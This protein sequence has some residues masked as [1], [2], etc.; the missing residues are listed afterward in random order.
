MKYKYQRSTL[1]Y[2]LG[3]AGHFSCSFLCGHWVDGEE[4]AVAIS[5]M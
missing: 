5:I 3:H 1:M 4:K 2:I